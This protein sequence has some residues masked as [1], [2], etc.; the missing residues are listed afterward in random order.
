MRKSQKEEKTYTW[1]LQDQQHKGNCYLPIQT[2]NLD[3]RRGL[4]LSNQF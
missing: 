4:I 3:C 1:R 2:M